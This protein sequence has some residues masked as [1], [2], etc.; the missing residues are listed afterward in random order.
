MEKFA[1]RGLVGFL[2]AAAVA[3]LGLAAAPAQSQ[4]TQEKTSLWKVS[5]GKATVYLLG[6]IHLLKE[7]DYPL[8]PRMGRALEESDVVVFEVHPDSLQA[9][10]LQA[11]VLE[12]AFLGE[13]ETLESAL[14]DSVYAAASARAES[15]GIDL[16]PMKMFK[17]W[18]VSIALALAEMQKMGFDPALGVEM[19]LA[20]EAEA[21]GKTILGLETGTYQIGLFASLTAEEQRALLMH[22]LSQLDDIEK[23]LGKILAAWKKGDTAGVEDTLNR[24]FKEYPEIYEKLILQRNRD[25][26]ARIEGFL[27]GGETHLVVVGVGHMPGEEGL[28]DLLVKKGFKVEQL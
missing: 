17:P 14:G 4:R 6:S 20:A 26:L 22:T 7:D 21:K 24:S 27:A 28:L 1:R 3:V 10:S 12:N 2:A 9:A 23:E 16:G 5:G 8:D 18:F 25:W 15:L 19:H 13:G 11:Y